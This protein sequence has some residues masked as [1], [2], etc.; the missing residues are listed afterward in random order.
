MEVLRRIFNKLTG[1]CGDVDMHQKIAIT[2]F[3][4]DIP[5]WVVLM[6][7]KSLTSQCTWGE[8]PKWVGTLALSQIWQKENK[9]CDY[10]GWDQNYTIDSNGAKSTPIT[11]LDYPIC[12]LLYLF[13]YEHVHF[14]DSNL[15]HRMFMINTFKSTGLLVDF[16]ITKD[17][18]YVYSH[19]NVWLVCMQF[20]LK[21][22]YINFE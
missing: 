5:P 13:P 14:H 4:T 17:L 18:M 1:S 21:I 15:N 6:S 12:V 16:R 2:I 10:M 8:A 9:N 22:T 20:L 19:Q 11:H 7:F 3:K